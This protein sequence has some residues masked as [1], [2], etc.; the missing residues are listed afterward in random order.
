MCV[1]PLVFPLLLAAVCAVINAASRIQRLLDAGGWEAVRLQEVG[2]GD[3]RNHFQTQC[4]TWK[5]VTQAVCP[6]GN[7]GGGTRRRYQVM[8]SSV[9]A[10][11]HPWLF[12]LAWKLIKM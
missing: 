8:V 4:P 12:S 1:Y 6:G 9:I 2:P 11:G 7:Q 10:P 5:A 3:Q